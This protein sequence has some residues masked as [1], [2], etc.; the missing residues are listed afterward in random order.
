[1]PS[2][3]VKEYLIVLVGIV[4]QS[5][6]AAVM[7]RRKLY[8][9]WPGFFSYMIHILQPGLDII[10][11]IQKWNL[12]TYYYFFYA[13]ESL[14]LALSFVV[15]YE[16]FLSVMDPYDA[17]MRVGK[18]LF[19]GTGGVL[20]ALGLLFVVFGPTADGAMVFKV[21]FYSERSLRIVQ[22]GLLMLLFAISRS[23]ALSW[24]S[25]AFGIAMGST[26]AFSW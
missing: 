16:V 8:R 22:V 19:F 9:Q 17:L 11:V 12:L 6:I 23:L 21:V 13:V 3:G 14:S 5:A 4:L 24:R 20:L 10:G 15:I 1:M 25:I 26:P 2:Y 18:G 7:M